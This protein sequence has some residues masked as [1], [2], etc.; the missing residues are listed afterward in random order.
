M[1]RAD[2]AHTRRR[3]TNNVKNGNEQ[4]SAFNYIIGERE[5]L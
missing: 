2:T 5:A 1:L 3:Q 4:S